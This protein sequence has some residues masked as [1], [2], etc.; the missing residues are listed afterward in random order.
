MTINP[1]S[2]V[3]GATTDRVA[4]R[5]AGAGV[6]LRSHARGRRRWA[7][8]SAARS[9]S[10][11]DRHAIT[12]Q[13]GQLQALD[14]AGRRKPAARSSSTPS[15]VCVR[16]IAPARRR[17]DAQHRRAARHHASV[18]ARAGSEPAAGA[19]RWRCADSHRPRC[20]RRRFEPVAPAPWRRRLLCIGP[21]LVLAQPAAPAASAA[22]AKAAPLPAAEAQANACRG[23]ESPPH[24]QPFTPR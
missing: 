23:R 8:R 5:S 20:G 11:R 4:R 15:S 7:P 19:W 10:G 18:R 9:T 13:A 3:T 12:L 2:A 17:G 1:V 21:A 22:S 24:R 16:E 14:A 6:L